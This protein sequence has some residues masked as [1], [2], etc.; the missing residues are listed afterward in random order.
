ML[1]ACRDA[2]PTAAGVDIFGL[3][4]TISPACLLSGLVVQKTL[5][6]RQL[7]W[8]AWILSI[9]GAALLGTLDEN[10]SRSLCYAY[11]AIISVGSG[12]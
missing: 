6:Y 12:A 5:R 11:Q 1:Q 4:Y 7:L 2:G 3:S 10:S 8:L 9:V